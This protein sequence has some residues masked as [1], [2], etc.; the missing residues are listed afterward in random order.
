MI[1][2]QSGYTPIHIAIDNG[3]TDAIRVL[4]GAGGDVNTANEVSTPRVPKGR[5]EKLKKNAYFPI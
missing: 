2:N 3:H 1:S 4:I 5:R